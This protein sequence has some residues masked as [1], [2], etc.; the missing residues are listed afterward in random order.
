MDRL[1]CS[2]YMVPVFSLLETYLRKPWSVGPRDVFHCKMLQVNVHD[3]FAHICEVLRARVAM[4]SC[5]QGASWNHRRLSSTCAAWP[6]VLDALGLR[7]GNLRS[8]GPDLGSGFFVNNQYRILL[9][10]DG[11]G[12]REFSLGEVGG[13]SRGWFRR[14]HL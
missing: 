5:Y 1:A 7:I 2:G 6:D 8:R 9:D 11:A 4:V 14:P 13:R 12:S 10:R 3:T